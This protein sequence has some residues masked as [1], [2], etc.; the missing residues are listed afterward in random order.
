MQLIKMTFP[1]LLA[2]ERARSQL[3]NDIFSFEIGKIYHILA[4]RRTLFMLGEG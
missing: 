2:C 3:S 4:T 1:L